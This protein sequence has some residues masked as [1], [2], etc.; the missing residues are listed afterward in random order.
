MLSDGY[1]SVVVLMFFSYQNVA[2]IT[3]DKV[4]SVINM[5]SKCCQISKCCQ[6]SKCCRKCCP[7]RG[8]RITE[9]GVQ[10]LLLAVVTVGVVVVVDSAG[11]EGG[12]RLWSGWPV[13]GVHP[14][15]P[16]PHMYVPGPAGP[17][18]VLR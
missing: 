2:L 7:D 5:L 14:V 16:P 12:G 6:L 11:V 1:H 10:L 9:S 17:P 4:F 8:P 18:H 3:D 15:P 13:V